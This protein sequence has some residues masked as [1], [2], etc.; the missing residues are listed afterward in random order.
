MGDGHS[1]VVQFVKCY[2]AH[3]FCTCSPGPWGGAY[4]RGNPGA[5]W[6]DAMMKGWTGDMGQGINATAAAEGA[7][8]EHQAAHQAATEA[9]SAAHKAAAEAAKDAAAAHQ[10]AAAIAAANGQVS[11]ISIISLTH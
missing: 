3:S 9:A 11:F 1:I 10:A 2:F 5:K 4:G 6:F 8:T 7:N